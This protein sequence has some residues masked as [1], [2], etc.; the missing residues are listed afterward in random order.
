M[1]LFKSGIV[2]LSSV[3]PSV[4]SLFVFKQLLKLG[5]FAFESQVESCFVFQI[6]EPKT[7][8]EISLMNVRVGL[9]VKVEIFHLDV[10][11]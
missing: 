3:V 5:S 10:A 1:L 6:P 7:I 11:N 9:N 8:Q 2:E 4:V